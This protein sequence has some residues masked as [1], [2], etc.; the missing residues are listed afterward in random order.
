[1]LQVL[2][3]DFFYFFFIDGLLAYYQVT[4]AS[5]LNVLTLHDTAAAAALSARKSV[6]KHSDA[7]CR[8]CTT[9]VQSM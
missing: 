9:A 6:R 7:C 5:P 1:M 8:W 3:R 4:V 2:I